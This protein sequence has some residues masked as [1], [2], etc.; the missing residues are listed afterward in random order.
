MKRRPIAVQVRLSKTEHEKL[1]S[2]AEHCNLTVSEYI[3]TCIISGQ[4]KEAP[5]GDWFEM[6]KQLRAIGN[7]LN[8]IAYVANSTGVI[9]QEN[10]H[11]LAVNFRKR[12]REIEKAVYNNGND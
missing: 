4:P 8:Q 12:L 5:T 11:E 2:N 7:S 3:R 6:A 10:Y 9:D 1:R